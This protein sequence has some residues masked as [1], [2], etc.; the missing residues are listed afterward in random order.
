MKRDKEQEMKNGFIDELLGLD[1]V[2]TIVLVLGKF[3]YVVYSLRF[4][5]LVKLDKRRNCREIHRM[6]TS[7][8]EGLM[9]SS[10]VVLVRCRDSFVVAAQPDICSACRGTT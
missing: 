3:S 8:F 9:G 4:G 1:F 5:G 10:V 7:I 2:D 6:K